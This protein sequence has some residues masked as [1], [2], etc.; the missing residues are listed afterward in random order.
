MEDGR[1]IH[2]L[3]VNWCSKDDLPTD[4]SLHASQRG[5]S[6]KEGRGGERGIM[7]HTGCERHV[8]NDDVLEDV[9]VRVGHGARCRAGHVAQKV[10]FF[11]FHH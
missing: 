2:F 11:A 4:M 9:V 8:P 1:D 3:S 10:C 5:R 6:V 7:M